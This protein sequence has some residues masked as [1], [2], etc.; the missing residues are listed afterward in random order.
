MAAAYSQI[1]NKHGDQVYRKEMYG[2]EIVFADRK[3]FQQRLALR[4][5]Q[6]FAT[7]GRYWIMDLTDEHPY[8]LGP[9]SNLTTQ[10]RLSRHRLFCLQIL[11]SI[12]RVSCMLQSV[13]CTIPN[14]L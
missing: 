2:V 4:R 1:L 3:K 8:C 7:C 6:M 13:P 5:S 10:R 9:Q 14:T 12:L 11:S